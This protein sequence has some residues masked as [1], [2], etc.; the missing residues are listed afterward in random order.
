MDNIDIF[1]TAFK[2]YKEYVSDNRYKVV[3]VKDYEYKGEL[4]WFK[5]NIGDNISKM[6]WFF[7]ELT[8]F[9][10]VW[11]NYGMKDYVGMCSYRR[12]FDFFDDIDSIED[13]LKEYDIILPCQTELKPFATNRDHYDGCHNLEDLDLLCNIINIKHP[14]YKDSVEYMLNHDKIYANNMFIMKREDFIRYCEFIF[15]IFDE[16]LNI[17]GFKTYEDICKYIED[18]SEKYL[19]GKG[20]SSKIEYQSRLGGFLAERLFTV[21]IHHNFKKVYE[22]QMS[23]TEKVGIKIHFE[24]YKIKNGKKIKI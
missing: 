22:Q 2:D 15:E 17:R 5:D 13:K 14:T 23:F 24:N 7:N 4:E 3:C 21:Y 8:T 1:I 18:N 9:Y 6:N 16:F 10:W 20:I 19:K 12:Y 11:K